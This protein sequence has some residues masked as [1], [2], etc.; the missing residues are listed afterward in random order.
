[1]ASKQLQEI[2]NQLYELKFQGEITTKSQI[3]NKLQEVVAYERMRILNNLRDLSL[4]DVP[5]SLY[6]GMVWRAILFPKHLVN[7][8]CKVAL[9]YARLIVEDKEMPEMLKP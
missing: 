5:I 1:M 9:N 8:M 3:E 4:S 2:T 7:F 6:F